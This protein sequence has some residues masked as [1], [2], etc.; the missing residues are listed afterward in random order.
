[1]QKEDT[2]YH[3]VDVREI[4][5]AMTVVEYTDGFY[6]NE[7]VREVEISH[8]RSPC[9]SI[10]REEAQFRGGDII[11]LGIGVWHQLVRLFVAA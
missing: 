3:V 6:G 7:L 1:M 8:V 2:F 10:D 11:Q 5:E 9:R 4:P